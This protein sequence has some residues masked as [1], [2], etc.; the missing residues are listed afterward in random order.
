MSALAVTGFVGSGHQALDQG[1][2][3]ILFAQTDVGT[4]VYTASGPMGG[5]TAY[6][7]APDGRLVLYDTAFF[8]G[9][10]A[11]GTMT[12]LSLVASN[13][14]SPSLVFASHRS[15]GIV[16]LEVRSDGDLGATT[17]F[18][19]DGTLPQTLGLNQWGSDLLFLSSAGEAGIS[20]YA[21]G[22]G[23]SLSQRV[24]ATDT[25]ATYARSVFA[26]ETVTVGG[27]DYLIG[28]CQVECGI[29]A[30]RIG[31][32]DLMATGN[33][34]MAEGLGIMT[35]TDLATVVV[36]GKTFVLVASAPSDGI[37]Q[38]GA[39]TVLE[40]ALDGSLVPTD[41]VIDTTATRFGGAQSLDVV[42]VGGR[43][44]VL[45][46]GG[47][48]GL[49]AFVLLPNGR[50]VVADT[51]TDM[52]QGGLSN[53]T[54]IAA[55]AM[56][57]TVQMFVASQNNAGLTA[58]RL[59]AT[60]TGQTRSVDGAAMG[61]AQNDILIGGGGDDTLDGGAGDDI[62]EDGL[63]QDQL[64]GGA[65]ADL[66]VLRADATY[67]AILDFDWTEDRIDL[68]DWPFFYDPVSLTIQAT[69]FGATVIWRGETLDLHSAAGQ[70][71]SPIQVMMGIIDGVNRSPNLAELGGGA[72]DQMLLGSPVGDAIQGGAG[73][74]TIDGGNGHDT[75]NGGDDEDLITGGLGDDDLSGGR[76]RDTLNGGAGRDRLIGGQG[77]DDLFGDDGDDTIFGSA[78][79]DEV[80]GGLGDDWI[81]GGDQP[82]HL[83]GGS[84]ADTILGGTGNDRINGGRDGDEV[85]GDG[86][87]DRI[88]AGPGE[89][90]V[91]GGEGNDWIS[92]Q[93]QSDLIFGDDGD[94][95][96]FG[97]G[98]FDTVYGG[99]GDD[100]LNGGGNVDR[101]YGGAGNDTL[102]G[103]SGGDR[104]YG[105][106]GVD[107]IYG[108][109]G[110]DRIYGGDGDDVIAGSG[111]F[112]RVFGEAGDDVIDGG[113]NADF[114]SGGTG[115]DT[116]TGDK[117]SDDLRGDADDDLLDGEGGND[118]LNGGS[119]DD[120]LIGG[121]GDDRLIG[122]A[123]ADVFVFADGH[124]T[125]TIVD[126]DTG[127]VIDLSAFPALGDFDALT[128]AGGAAAQVGDD[129]RIDTDG[130]TIWMAG[131]DLGGLEAG[132]FLF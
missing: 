65:G 69:A 102:N 17:T 101:L 53:V 84:G 50:L 18:A 110:K 35:P 44:Y 59:N 28:A 117:G 83:T 118:D 109:G 27:V 26:M 8:N 80:E 66:F 97:G 39:L 55:M 99:V 24:S 68:S 129:V 43:T 12:D 3:D 92:G 98:G 120:R 106:D 5:V 16:G 6:L 4:V 111:G 100:S 77:D 124:G 89:D 15:D 105:D 63:G 1:I 121:A 115:R 2:S 86:G 13:S 87:K 125:D 88:K 93:G 74:D 25:D 33:M 107:H 22:P 51:I 11:D 90:M 71:L 95:D 119:G 38:S 131:V 127:D 78:G 113:A 41:H 14:G 61:G 46:A 67:D 58:L 72:G 56:G 116:L 19:S 49:T 108:K 30:W 42:D 128:G 73:R 76:D 123:G 34:G 36:D 47:D 32:A 54:S 9:D 7:V 52:G 70:S 79:R 85:F 75:L 103:G 82:D 81:D 122:G 64:R 91:Y 62:L 29:T 20:G 21:L 31:E 40:V 45:A 126:F 48:D 132:D 10:W 114:L 57:S 37:G 112:D 60:D 23:D 104:L 94:D 130:G 96:L